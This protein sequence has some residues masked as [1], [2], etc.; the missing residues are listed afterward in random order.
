[1]KII[2]KP[3]AAA[4]SHSPCCNIDGVDGFLPV[5]LIQCITVK[6]GRMTT[7]HL[8]LPPRPQPIGPTPN[9]NT[10][11]PVLDY[12]TTALRGLG[13]LRASWTGAISV[14]ERFVIFWPVTHKP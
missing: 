4:A 7:R 13:R 5:E 9:L 6:K 2:G 8:Q 3:G 1:M 10:L 11:G 14:S 12:A